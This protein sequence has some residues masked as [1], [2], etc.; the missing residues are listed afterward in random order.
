[1]LANL[2]H[3]AHSAHRPLEL[4]MILGAIEGAFFKW[5]AAVDGSVACGAHF[6]LGKLVKF[7]FNSVVGVTLAL[8]LH[9]LSL[10][11]R[12]ASIQSMIF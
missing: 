5:R 3:F 4:G 7:D 11:R 2:A 1:M 6:E 10:F 12:L 9:P 8:S